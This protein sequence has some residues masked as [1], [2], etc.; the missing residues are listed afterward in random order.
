MSS[1]SDSTTSTERAKLDDTDISYMGVCACVCVTE[2]ERERE[3]ENK[4]E[5]LPYYCGDSPAVRCRSHS[6]RSRN[7]SLLDSSPENNDD[8]TITY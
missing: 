6:G 1:N 7:N 2:R 5:S 4:Q 8:V 3:R